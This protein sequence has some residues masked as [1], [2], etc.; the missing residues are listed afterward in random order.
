LDGLG[1]YLRFL[2]SSEGK[3]SKVLKGKI[4]GGNSI[5]Q[6]LNAEFE[7]CLKPT[8]VTLEL[9]LDD[10]T[11]VSSA[12]WISTESLELS[13]RKRDVQRIKE[14]NGRYGLITLLNQFSQSSGSVEF[15]V[16][17]LQWIDF[18]DLAPHIDW[19]RRRILQRNTDN[20]GETELE[21]IDLGTLEPNQIMLKILNRHQ[22][23]LQ[24]ALLNLNSKEELDETLPRV[25]DLFL[26]LS[27]ITI[28][29][30]Q[31]KPDLIEELR[32][33]WFNSI[34]AL[35]T[36]SDLAKTHSETV[37]SYVRELSLPEHMITLGYFVDQLQKNQGYNRRYPSVVGVFKD[38]L[39]RIIKFGYDSGCFPDRKTSF[40]RF[41]EIAKEYRE[42]KN[43]DVDQDRLFQFFLNLSHPPQNRF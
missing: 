38:A 26:F 5:T 2:N 18:D 30:V 32:W 17:S 36:L 19:A 15:L 1:A 29:F 6:E 33:I 9:K 8:F 24:K 28:W 12:R 14:S 34:T 21:L 41:E 31:V 7:F 35:N 22:K 20:G 23:K 13:P 4:S 10:R 40:N 3:E 27:K 39:N 43:L 25:F 42:F 37:E 16:Y 11:L